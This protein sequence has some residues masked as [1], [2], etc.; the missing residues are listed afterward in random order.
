MAHT[1]DNED[2]VKGPQ[3]KKENWNNPIHKRTTWCNPINRLEKLQE[4]VYL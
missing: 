1:F 4:L 3:N 2:G